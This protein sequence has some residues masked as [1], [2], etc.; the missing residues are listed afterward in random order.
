MDLPRIVIFDLDGT[1]APSKSPV[2]DS[3]ADWLVR[4]LD[5]VDVCIISGATY[6]QMQTQVVGHLE[7]AADLGRLHLMPTCGTQFY[8]YVDGAWTQIY[9]ETLDATTKQ[10]IA[11]VLTRGAQELDLTSDQTWGPLIEDRDTQITYSGLGQQAPLAAKMAWDPD[12][13]KKE[14]L[15]AYAAT[16]LPELEVRAGGSTSIDVT[17]RGI[18]KA[19]GVTKLGKQLGLS[20]DDMLFMGDRLDEAGNDYPVKTLGVRCIAVTGWQDTEGHI[21]EIVASFDAQSS[22]EG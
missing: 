22:S 19:Y 3:T 10:T 8:G 6:T 4:L 20:F 15:R 21:A 12:G 17:R 11:D 1:L 18:D 13:T 5:R 7:A 16:R 2:A 14:R 9:S